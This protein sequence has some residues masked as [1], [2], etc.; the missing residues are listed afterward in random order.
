M[1]RQP[2]GFHGGH[3]LHL[4]RKEGESIVFPGRSLRPF[5]DD[6]IEIVVL[7][8]VG[9]KVRLGIDAPDAIEV[10]RHEVWRGIRREEQR[11]ER[12]NGNFDT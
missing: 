12:D 3:M 4:S 5:D 9:D 10:Y 1:D 7:D 2:A 11:K 6:Q 8:I